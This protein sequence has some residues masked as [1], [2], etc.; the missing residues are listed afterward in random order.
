MATG[1]S[2]CAALAPLLGLAA[3]NLC[4]C[5]ASRSDVDAPGP[6]AAE[7]G[8]GPV[9]VTGAG[10]SNTYQ[11]SESLYRGS[12]PTPDGFRTLQRLGIRTIVNLRLNHSDLD[13]MH[14][15]GVGPEAFAYE[16]IRMAAWDAD[17]PEVLAFLRIATT[18]TR[19]PV[20]VHCEHGSDRT[21]TMVAAYR[22]IVQGWSKDAAIREMRDGPFGFHWIWQGLPRFI[23]RM[24]VARYRKTLGLPPAPDQP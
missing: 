5:G 22:V 16:H 20:F 3:A 14:A 23:E 7:H 4:G 18:P 2:R 12:Q 11:V 24:D 6:S 21:G 1:S 9:P 13:E 15:S 17:E 19:A 10:L 8:S